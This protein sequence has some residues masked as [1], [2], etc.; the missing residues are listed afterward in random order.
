MK[1]FEDRGDDRILQVGMPD[2]DTGVLLEVCKY[3]AEGG[4][5]ELTKVL[6]V[7]LPILVR[8][9]LAG[10]LR[11]V[12]AGVID[13]IRRIGGEKSCLVAIHEA[14]D[15]ISIGRVPAEKA[16][17]TENPEI[18]RAGNGFI[19]RISRTRVVDRS[20]VRIVVKLGEERVDVLLAV[21]HTIQSIL[22]A[23]L[24]EELGQSGFVPL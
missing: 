19:G 2:V 1:F 4:A 23:E 10:I 16:V 6:D 14:G 24:L 8:P 12:G 20:G 7:D 22:G 15:V 11:A 3:G 13:T 17:I 9:V 21:P 5:E 18:T